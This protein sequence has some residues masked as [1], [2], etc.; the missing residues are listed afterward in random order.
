MHGGH[1]AQWPY[2]TV[3]VLHCG[4]IDHIARWPYCTVSILRTIRGLHGVY[5]A[6][7]MLH[8]V[9]TTRWPYCTVSIL[10]G[11]HRSSRMVK[12]GR[13]GL[14]LIPT[15]ASSRL[16][17]STAEGSNPHGIESILGIWC[18]CFV[19]CEIARALARC[20]AHRLL[21]WPAWQSKILV[22]VS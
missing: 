12:A 22:E 3:V 7:S 14:L 19:A 2:C 9:H 1:I 17:L 4:L 15:C 6:Q 18:N 8:S 13:C 5:I 21:A 20:A 10:H 16:L 11:V